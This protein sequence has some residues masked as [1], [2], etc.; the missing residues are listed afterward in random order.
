MSHIVHI[1]K[2]KKSSF[3]LRTEF[4]MGT[5]KTSSSRSNSRSTELLD[6]SGYISDFGSGLYGLTP[7]GQ[8][9]RNRIEDLVRSKHEAEGFHEVSIPSLQYSGDWK[10]SGRWGKFEG[11]MF[12]F[13]NRE[14]SE[15]C[16]APTHEEGIVRM[17]DGVV[18]SYKD[19]PVTVFQIKEKHRDDRAREGLL[20]GKEFIMKD[21]Y[22]MH[23]DEQS[24][25]E[26]YNVIKD[27][28]RDIFKTLGLEVREVGA[29]VGVMGGSES[30]EFVAPSEIGDDDLIYCTECAFGVTDEHEHFSDFDLEDQCPEC[31]GG[32]KLGNGVEVGHIFALGQR[33]SS[34]MDFKF[35]KQSGESEDVYMASYGIGITRVMQTIIDQKSQGDSFTWGVNRGFTPSPFDICVIRGDDIEDETVERLEDVVSESDKRLLVYEGK[36]RIGEQFS[37][38]DLIGIPVKIILGNHWT[39]ENEVEIETYDGGKMYS[40][41]DELDDRIEEIW[42]PDDS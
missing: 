37:E 27:V 4:T 14:G 29:D 16:L 7:L 40:K 31:G 19:L 12:T 28:Y 42:Q 11:E 21:A 32:L 13:E 41:L 10:E 20:R 23:A 18:R 39:S 33:Y 6:R 26:T 5:T 9:S 24:M 25:F 36:R 8:E 15:M 34:S 2:N 1:V 3:V 30:M 35:D 22:S 38:S 17:F